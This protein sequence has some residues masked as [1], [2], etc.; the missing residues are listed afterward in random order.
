[1]IPTRAII[2]IGSIQS[3]TTP[4]RRVNQT[5]DANNSL[6]TLTKIARTEKYSNWLAHQLCTL[7]YWISSILNFIE[8]SILKCLTYVTWSIELLH[9]VRIIPAGFPHFSVQQGNLTVQADRCLPDRLIGLNSIGHVIHDAYLEDAPAQ[10]LRHFP[11][12]L[13]FYTYSTIFRSP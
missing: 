4:L 5:S 1:M 3:I 6:A 11:S 8:N 7:K 2:Q 13:A 9:L 10:G 12:R